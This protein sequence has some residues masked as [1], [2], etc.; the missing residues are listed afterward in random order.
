MADCGCDQSGSRTFCMHHLQD[1]YDALEAAKARYPNPI[2]AMGFPDS[3]LDAVGS[4]IHDVEPA[5]E[6]LGI[7][8]DSA[9]QTTF[10]DGLMMGVILAARAPKNHAAHVLP[11]VRGD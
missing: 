7:D 8:I 10:I 1:A 9:A 5:C 2:S 6:Q 4:L 3:L 11:E